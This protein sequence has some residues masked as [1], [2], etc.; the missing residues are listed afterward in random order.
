MLIGTD[1]KLPWL[2]FK[3]FVQLNETTWFRCFREVDPVT[4]QGISRLHESCEGRLVQITK[5][6]E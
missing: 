4:S 6:L 1:L 2:A 5:T 3:L